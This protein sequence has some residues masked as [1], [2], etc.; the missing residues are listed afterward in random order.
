MSKGR[1]GAATG[2]SMAK[3]FISDSLISKVL[4]ADYATKKKA[5]TEKFDRRKNRSVFSDNVILE[6]RRLEEREGLDSHGIFENLASRGVRISRAQ[7][8]AFL[9]RCT[10]AELVPHQKD[11]PYDVRNAEAAA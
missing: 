11:E 4:G 8:Y 10:R 3:V 2:E 9:Q 1:L 7:I 5:V 6:V